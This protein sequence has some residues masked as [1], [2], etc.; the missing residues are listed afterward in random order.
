MFM[1]ILFMF[2]LFVSVR[3]VALSMGHNGLGIGEG[4]AFEKRQFK[5]STKAD[6]SRNVQL[7]SSALLLPIPC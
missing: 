5:Y 6:S 7:V 2:C 3:T 1:S 4:R